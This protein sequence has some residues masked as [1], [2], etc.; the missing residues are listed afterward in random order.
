MSHLFCFG[1]G[2]TARC[3]GRRL[4]AEGWRVSGT[5]RTSEAAKATA[6][7][8]FA[9]FVFDGTGPG[10]SIREVL[11]T[12]THVLVS[13]P[14]AEDVDPVL[15]HHAGD[16]EAAASIA[17]IGYLSTVGVYGDHGGAWVDETAP[18][19]P[20]S[21]RS[22]RRLAAEEAW[23]AFGARNG[24]R[25]QIFRLA[26]IYGPKRS[27]IDRLRA[28][29][30]QRIV[31]PGQVF[32]RIHVEDIAEALSAAIGG[33]GAHAV[34]NVADDEP[35][36][37]Q[38]VILFAADLLHMAPPPEIA[39]EDAGLSPMAASFYVENK[40]VSNARM[41]EDLGVSLKFPSYRE[42]LRAILGLS[43]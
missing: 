12:A 3:L 22:R 13:V 16:L 27:A 6:A 25:V 11:Q 15:A 41:H 28:G 21:E 14:P 33:R 37:P 38:D 29:T 31:K 8:G 34:Y 18:P 5:A 2:Y 32:N 17:W 42:G 39:F 26:G 40:R 24:T 36:P 23:R 35:A 19:N 10:T 30:A 1:L 43:R 9:P 20:I 4:A 7:E